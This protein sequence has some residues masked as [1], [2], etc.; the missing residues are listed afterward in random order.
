M[1]EPTLDDQLKQAQIAK[2]AAETHKLEKE[3]AAVKTQVRS[4]FWSEAIKIL[5]GVVLGIGG[6]T[7][8]YTQYE[9]G[10]LKAKIAREDLA[11]AQSATA[12]AMQ[13]KLAADAAVA[14]ALAKR[15]AALRE[16]RDAEAAVAELKAS[17][18]KTD[19]A[20]QTATPGASKG[21]L[22][23]I[24]FRG[25]LTRDVIN[26]L[27]VSLAEKS[28]NAPGAERVSGEYQNLVKYFKPTESGDAERLASAVESFFAAK[29]CPVKLRVVPAATSAI[30]NPPLEVWLALKCSGR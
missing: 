18:T 28:F 23:F 2:T 11:K 26:E 5:G 21:R 30:A 10:E 22:A 25:D 9:V 14:S 1:P 19:S 24:Q 4:D 3:A 27:R 13:A 8:A 7:V 15:D 17:L 20:L 6:V 12:L 29:R 16:Q